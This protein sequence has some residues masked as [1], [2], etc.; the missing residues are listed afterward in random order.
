MFL[1][2]IKGMSQDLAS[3]VVL[4]EG[5]ELLHSDPDIIYKDWSVLKITVTPTRFKIY[6]NDN[7]VKDIARTTAPLVNGRAFTFAFWITRPPLIG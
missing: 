2:Q 1:R 4:F 7:L 5:Q 6:F 3:R